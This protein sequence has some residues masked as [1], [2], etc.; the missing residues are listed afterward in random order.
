MKIAPLQAFWQS[1]HY[2]QAFSVII[3]NM[4]AG[5]IFVLALLPFI[6]F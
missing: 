1:S 2:R 5:A 6:L 3:D 4:A